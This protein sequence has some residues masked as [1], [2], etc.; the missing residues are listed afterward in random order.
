MTPLLRT[1]LLA[2]LVAIPA[3]SSA[4]DSYSPNGSKADDALPGEETE[5]EI[6]EDGSF[7]DGSGIGCIFGD[8]LVSMARM[9]DLNIDVD[10]VIEA[11]TELTAIQQKQVFEIAQEFE[12]DPITSL[13]QALESTDEAS[14]DLLT[15]HDTAHDRNFN[16]YIYSAGDNIV[17]RI[18]YSQSLRVAAEVGDGSIA[19]CDAGF[20]NYDDLP[21]FYTN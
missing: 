20:S 5:E 17:G 21:W 11:D 18:Y 14:M 1:L 15:V 10:T 7:D 19:R 9:A 8:H 13:E 4:G 2:S 6:D 12:V 3:C 16:M